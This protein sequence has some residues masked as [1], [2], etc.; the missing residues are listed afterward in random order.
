MQRVYVCVR[1]YMDMQVCVCVYM[2]MQ[3]CVCVCVCVLGGEG[4]VLRVRVILWG[5]L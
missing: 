4:G 5:W 1:V 2:D 3:V